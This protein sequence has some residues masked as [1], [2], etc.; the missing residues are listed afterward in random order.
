[1]LLRKFCF[2]PG[3]QFSMG[4]SLIPRSRVGCTWSRASPSFF[5]PMGW[6]KP[7]KSQQIRWEMVGKVWTST[8]PLLHL[9]DVSRSSALSWCK[10]FRVSSG[11][12]LDSSHLCA[13]FRWFRSSALGMSCIE[14]LDMATSTK[15]RTSW[16]SGEA[17]IHGIYFGIR[18]QQAENSKFIVHD[19]SM[20]YIYIY[21]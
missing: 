4:S 12:F 7:Q 19:S 18:L 15:L 8:T 11:I 20:D 5:G 2:K 14:V 3:G 17:E 21:M 9:V 6:R 13:R 1:M 16:A 10:F